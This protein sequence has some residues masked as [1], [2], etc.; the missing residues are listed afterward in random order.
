MADQDDIA[1]AGGLA[2]AV[3]DRLGGE[4]AEWS[5]AVSPG[6]EMR[7]RPVDVEH[8][9][10]DLRS[11][12]GEAEGVYYTVGGAFPRSQA[13]V[14][15]TEQIQEHAIAHARGAAIPP[16]PGHQHPL[17]ARSINSIVCWVCPSDQAHH[18]S[19]VIPG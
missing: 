12:T 9:R 8:L 2:R 5:V 13:I 4:F 3:L 14:A 17:V 11:P 15:T 10:I 19:P 6:E 1:F 18:S 7:P 16:C